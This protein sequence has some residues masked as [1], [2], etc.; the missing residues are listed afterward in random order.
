MCLYLIPACCI[1]CCN[2]IPSVDT[3]HFF[4]LDVNPSYY[5][6]KILALPFTMWA[7]CWTSSSI[8]LQLC[9]S[10]ITAACNVIDFLALHISLKWMD[11]SGA[12]ETAWED[13]IKSVTRRTIN[14]SQDWH[15][16][17]ASV[18]LDKMDLHRVSGV[19]L[20]QQTLSLNVGLFL[21]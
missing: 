13:K 2:K 15:A 14:L 10:P 11:G 12:A 17:A 18:S 4:L 8:S 6:R 9:N 1:F 21:L 19:P 7:L 5:Q 16:T 3:C 20:Q